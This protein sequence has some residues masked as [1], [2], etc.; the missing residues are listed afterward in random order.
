M[1]CLTMA[2]CQEIMNWIIDTVRDDA[3]KPV[4]VAILNQKGTVVASVK[5]DGAPDRCVHLA[6]HKAYTAFR[7]E[8]TSES[9][10]ARLEREKLEIAFF[11]DP[12]LTAFPGG[13]PIL[14]ADGEVIGAVGISGRPS[15]EDQEL[16]SYAVK[17][18]CV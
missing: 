3:G 7:M 14:A 5:M 9:F 12:K 16:A 1:A 2:M 15:E 17:L 4:A 6:K 8:T 13:A 11:C 10:G 18:G